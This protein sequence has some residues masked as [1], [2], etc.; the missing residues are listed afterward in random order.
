MYNILIDALCKDKKM[1][2]A[3]DLFIMLSAKGLHH[4]VKTYN[5]MIRGLCGGLLDEA[6]E[7]FVVME[8]N[9]C[10]PD[11]VTFNTIIWGFLG[12]KKYSEALLHLDEMVVK[13]FSVDVST[14]SRIVDLMSTRGEDPALQQGIKSFLPKDTHGRE[15]IE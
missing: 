5:I 7:F 14:S 13:G 11:D 10:S 8:Q 4:N 3:R 1:D 6:K 9:G 2:H 15:E 12:T